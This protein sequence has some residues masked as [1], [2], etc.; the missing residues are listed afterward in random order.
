MKS[1]TTFLKRHALVMGIVLMFLL[2]WPIEIGRAAETRGLL[3]FHI[4]LVVSL[5]VG[6][7]F[8]VASIV[9]TWL[10]LGK[11]DVIALLK[12]FVLWRV[13]FKWYLVAFLLLPAINGIAI[14]LNATLSATPIDFSTAFAYT[15]FGRS[16]NLPVLILPWFVYEV[17]T[18]GEEIG[19]RGYVLPRLQAKHSA[20]LASLILGLVWGL[21]HL[22]KFLTA[23]NTSPFGWMM[24]DI[25]AK[26]VLYTWLYNNT[27]GSLLLVTFFH[28]ACNTAGVMLPI[29]NTVSGENQTTLM[30]VCGLEV[31]TALVV[32]V[33][34][35]PARLSRTA[36]LQMEV[37]S[38]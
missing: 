10:T 13:A 17:F 22:P 20:L 33:S 7:G 35:G 15:F 32:A 25:I 8:V 12:R 34:A 26:A 29:A 31:I 24:V 19:W 37:A 27:K 28:A 4:P 23:G 9:M 36:P 38:T 16:A 11:D 1:L 18:N 2:T 5:T 30:I 14:V 21:W 6:Y 3:P